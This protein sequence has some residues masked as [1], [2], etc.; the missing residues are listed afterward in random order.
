MIIVDIRDAIVLGNGLNCYTSDTSG[1]TVASFTV[2]CKEYDARYEKNIRYNNYRISVPSEMVEHVKRMKLQKGSMVHLLAT[3]DLSIKVLEAKEQQGDP[4][5]ESYGRSR[6][7]Q[8]LVLRLMHLEYAG[9]T[10]GSYSKTK[11]QDAQDPEKKE[12][13]VS[14]KSNDSADKTVVNPDIAVS[15]SETSVEEQMG[16]STLNLDE[17]NIFSKRETRR[18]F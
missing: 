9:T 6:S 3:M 15:N 13:N 7:I 14:E 4:E 5:S 17:N 2:G 1:S 10:G 12:P 11:D 16:I 8:G 18:F